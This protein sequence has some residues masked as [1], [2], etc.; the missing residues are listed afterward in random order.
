[1]GL[2]IPTRQEISEMLLA[3]RINIIDEIR[4]I[5]T[6][7]AGDAWLDSKDIMEYMKWSRRTLDKY[8]PD[9]PFRKLGKLLIRKSEFDAWL[10]QKFKEQ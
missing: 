1:M 9:I 4:R 5:I 8:R 3:E 10:E 6:P 7:P 2:E